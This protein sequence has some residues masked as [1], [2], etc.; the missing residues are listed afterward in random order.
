MLFVDLTAAFKDTPKK[1]QPA[2]A[3]I[4]TGSHEGREWEFFLPNRTWQC[5]YRSLSQIEAEG[6]YTEPD[7]P[8]HPE[9]VAKMLALVPKGFFG[10][11][12]R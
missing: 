3:F 10:K 2:C 12:K 8:L 9:V 11:R 6:S 1:G 5:V 4:A 7:V